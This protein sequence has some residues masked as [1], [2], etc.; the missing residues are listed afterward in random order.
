M[1]NQW[2]RS[3]HGAPTDPKWLGIA[4]KAGVAPGIV[5]ALVW[6]LLD[7][8]SQASERGS[9]AGY[10]ADGLACFMGCEVEQVETV[11]AL[12]HDKGILSGNAFTGWEKHQ[13]GRE[14]NSAERVKAHRE[15]KNAQR[16]DG[17]TQC[18]AD[19]TRCNAE[20]R[21]ETLD[22]DTDTDTDTECVKSAHT[23]EE[24]SDQGKIV[25][26]LLD[27]HAGDLTDWEQKFLIDVKWKHP[28]TKTQADTL[29]GIQG[30]V[31]PKDSPLRVLPTVKRG[32]PA[33]DAWVAYYRRQSRT[34]KTFHEAKD[35]FT[36]PT[37]FPPVE[38]AA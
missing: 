36:V 30:K 17:V 1:T 24:E 18:N 20:K 14:D 8:A 3:W 22:T 31:A 34:G 23:R 28:L 6:A 9:I 15:R 25:Q 7:R 35:E 29:K 37:E 2:F 13:P 21:A 11:I 33:Y 10:D 27:N 12:M 32:T 4:R 19:V 16:N 38:K 26:D 5:S